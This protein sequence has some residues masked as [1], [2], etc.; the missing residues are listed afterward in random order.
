M[1]MTRARVVW[2]SSAD[3]E[4][5]VT[6]SIEAALRQPRD[7]A[8]TAADARDMRE[9]IA[10]EKPPSGIW[11]LKLSPGGLVDIEFVAQYL[12][13]AWASRG[14][15]LLQQ[16][17]EA[18]L[19]IAEAGLADPAQVAVLADAW[20][21]QQNLS[22]LLKVALA[23]N[24]DPTREPKAFRAALARAGG[25]RGFPGLSAKLRAARTAAVAAYEAL[26]P[27]G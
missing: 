1:A 8:K 11:D 20:R 24:T 18:L 27:K 6:D 9:L 5:W 3:F 21:L 12:Q 13:I 15:P 17:G 10:A 7:I 26:I 25:A 19:A 23:D 4:I 2:A 16:T 14:G 22:Q